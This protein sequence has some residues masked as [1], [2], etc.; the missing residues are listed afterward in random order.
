MGRR[1]KSRECALQIVYEWQLGG[2]S[3]EAAIQAF[4]RIRSAT[5]A[6]REMTE[7]LARGVAAHAG[8]LD[9][10]IERASAHW[11]LERIAAVDRSVLRVGAYELLHEATPLAVVIDEAVELAR[12]FGERDS[13]AFV[14]GVLDAIARAAREGR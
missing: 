6:G 8:E 10:A 9:A 5:Q 11:R 3:V 12:R 13:P 14:N 2:E 1:T 7:R 4:W